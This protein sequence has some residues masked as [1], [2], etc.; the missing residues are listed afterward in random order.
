MRLLSGAIDYVAG[1]GCRGGLGAGTR[2]AM[3]AA[4]HSSV[5]PCGCT[6]SCSLAASASARSSSPAGPP[7]WP[8]HVQVGCPMRC[9][10]CATGKGGFARN[11]SPHEIMDQVMTVKE[12]LGKRVS[13]VVFMGMGE[14]RAAGV[15]R[16]CGMY[17]CRVT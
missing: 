7:P 16:A 5:L 15:L 9:S 8:L 10:F 14:V 1:T 11:L 12:T 6:P 2:H 13:N 4:G 17:M 3:G